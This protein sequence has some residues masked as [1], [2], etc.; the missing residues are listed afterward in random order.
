MCGSSR[1]MTLVDFQR[2]VVWV[3]MAISA[4]GKIATTNRNISTFGSDADYQR[5]L[6]IRS[7]SDAIL[8][9]A[10]TLNAAPVTLGNGGEDWTQKRLQRSLE[11]Y[12]QRILVSGSGSLDIHAKV[13]EKSFSPIRIL[14]TSQAPGS[15][16]ES[17]S[18][19]AQEVF[20]SPGE[21]IDWTLAFGWM[22]SRGIHRLLCEGG[23][24]LNGALLE[25]GF[26]DV[27]F[28]T[29]CPLVIGGRDAPT[30]FGGEGIPDLENALKMELLE[31]RTLESGE[32]MTTW[33]RQQPSVAPVWD[34]FGGEAELRSI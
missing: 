1:S 26:V 17:Y 10:G 16:L 18:Q 25:S 9:G 15:Q 7:F 19:I 12:P 24:E 31:A 3:N 23:G 21:V 27:L 14:T 6:K 34:A 8:C 29:I 13:F 32:R 28:L 5:L 22:K 11:P 33:V 2:P 4:D 30:A 20:I